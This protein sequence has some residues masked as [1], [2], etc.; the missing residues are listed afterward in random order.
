MYDI[1]NDAIRVIEE[2][3]LKQ[4][5]EHTVPL[6]A[7]TCNL[8]S[9]TVRIQ[10]E[11][12]EVYEKSFPQALMV[13]LSQGRPDL[14]REQN[15]IMQDCYE[16]LV[17]KRPQLWDRLNETLTQAATKYQEVQYLQTIAEENNQHDDQ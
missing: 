17:Q 15:E 11:L 5:Q 4:V 13:L 1:F 3:Q 14:T 2:S 7:E 10:Q 8:L 9:Q 6:L 12:L 16:A